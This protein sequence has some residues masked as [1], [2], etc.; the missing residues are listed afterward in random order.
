M[1]IQTNILEKKASKKDE[2]LFTQIYITASLHEQPVGFVRILYIEEIIANSKLST[3]FEFFIYKINQGNSTFKNIYENAEFDKFAQLLPM[4]GSN[5]DEIVE[6]I[7]NTYAKKHAEFV[8]YWVSK[9]SR[10]QTYVLTEKDTHFYFI[11]N[12]EEIKKNIRPQNFRGMGIGKFLLEKSMS[13]IEDKGL[14][15]WQSKTQTQQGEKFWEVSFSDFN[16]N[17]TESLTKYFNGKRAF[18]SKSL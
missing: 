7:S 1:D 17:N 14:H 5:F 16:I 3:P 15:L 2:N 18:S 4:Y 13:I 11:E 12:N 6:N 10:E 9:P 8:D